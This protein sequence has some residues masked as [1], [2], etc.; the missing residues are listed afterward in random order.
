MANHL[1][2][3]AGAIVNN[4]ATS[5]TSQVLSSLT[6][7]TLPITTGVTANNLR[8][9][10]QYFDAETGTHYNYF[11]DYDPATG[12]Y[13]QSDPIGLRGGINT[14]GYV[15]QKPLMS[16][17]P[18]GLDETIWR[19]G[20]GRGMGDG[21]RNGNWC[22]GN[23]S[24]GKVPSMNGGKDGSAPPLDSLDSCCNVHDNCYSKCEKL[25]KGLQDACFIKCDRELVGCLKGLDDDCTKWPNP[26]R[27]NTEGD[28]QTYRDDAMRIFNQ[29]MRDWDKQ[30][31]QSR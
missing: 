1:G 10:G 13:V 17:D 31:K 26:P 12:R 15:S 28:S 18:W 30:Q 6:Q 11:R 27:K 8:F 29:K 19:P 5:G 9:P 7:T 23:W 3:E 16:S 2:P 4:A 25:P 14:Y 24:G 20:P 21:P 22:G